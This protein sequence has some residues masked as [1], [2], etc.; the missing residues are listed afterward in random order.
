MAISDPTSPYYRRNNPTPLHNYAD[1]TN[2]Q[3]ALGQLLPQTLIL[4]DL[5]ALYHLFEGAGTTVNDN[6]PVASP[7]NGAINGSHF[8]LP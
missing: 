8:W 6:A 3:D 4:Q 2:S 5:I 1:V 7:N